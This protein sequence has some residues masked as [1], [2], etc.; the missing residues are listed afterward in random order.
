MTRKTSCSKI[1]TLV[2]RQPVPSIWRGRVE[3]KRSRAPTELRLIL[4]DGTFSGQLRGSNPR[5]QRIFD[6]LGA[7][8]GDI[9]VFPVIEVQSRRAA[10]CGRDRF[11]AVAW[12]N[13]GPKIF[14]HSKVDVTQYNIRQGR[15]DDGDYTQDEDRPASRLNPTIVFVN[16]R[17][18]RNNQD[19]ERQDS[20]EKQPP[21]CGSKVC[22]PGVTQ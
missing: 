12:D 14:S 17:D 21:T 20:D 8:I 1:R 10:L 5:P 18:N 4:T 15:I 6:A 19:S 2:F 9:H 22:P 13:S 7:E 16:G 3:I 11:N